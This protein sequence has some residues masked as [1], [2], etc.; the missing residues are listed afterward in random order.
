MSKIIKT[1]S[2][3]LK[4]YDST[5]PPIPMTERHRAILLEY[6]EVLVHNLDPDPILVRLVASGIF[7]IWEETT[8]Q[9]H[10]TRAKRSEE[11]LFMLMRK[12]DKAFDVFINAC[13]KCDMK[14][15]ASL[16]HHG[17]N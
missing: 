7:T 9:M 13:E 10:D 2:N 4:S 16:L 6:L 1:V 8:I 11:L 5:E 14:H 17:G 15:L 3:L 12:E